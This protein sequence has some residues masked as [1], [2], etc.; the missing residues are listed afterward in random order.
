MQKILS[1]IIILVLALWLIGYG[2]NPL[3]VQAATPIIFI[4]PTG[5]IPGTSVTVTGA[6]FNVSDT[7]IVVTYDTTVVASGIS[8]N[9]LGGWSFTFP[10]PTAS[11]AGQHMIGAYSPSTPLPIVSPVPFTVTPVIYINPTSGIP[12]SSVTVTGAG[13]TANETGVVVTYSGVQVASGISTNPQ[14]GWSATFTIPASSAG[15]HIIDAGGPLTLATNVPD[16]SFTITPIISINRASGAPGSSTA[17]TGSGFGAGETN[18][19]ITYDGT[20]VFSGIS[21]DSQGGWSATFTVPASTYGSHTIDASGTSTSSTNVPDITFAITPGISINPTS[22]LPGSLVTVTSSGFGAGETGISVIYDGTVVSSGISASTQGGWSITFTIPPSASGSHTI[23]ANG[24]ATLATNIPD[25][26]FTV[27]PGISIS[28]TSGVPG[29]SVV[30]TGFGFGAGETGISVT[31]DGTVVSS[32]AKA[33]P[34][35]SWSATF[36]VPTSASGSHRVGARGSV[37]QTTRVSEAD[38][39]IGPGISASP[40]FGNVGAKIEIIGS[41]FAAN[42]PLRFIYDDKDIPTEGTS[43]DASGSFSKSIVVP[44][45]KAGPHTIKVNDGQRNESKTTF[46]MESTPPPVPAPLSPED[47]ARL[48]LLGGITPTLKWTTVTDPSGV[49]FVLQ[50]DTNPDFTSVILEKTD[51]VG[52]RYTLTVTEALPKGEYYWRVRAIDGASNQ[53]AWSA[54]RT[55]KSGL[56][57]LSTLVILIVLAVVVIAGVVYL[58]VIRRPQRRPARFPVPGVEMPQVVPGQWR[59]LEPE[60]SAR[61]RALPRILALPQP[62]KRAKTLSTE[63]MGRVKVILDF[64]QSLPLV[65][66]GYTANWLVDLVETSMGIEMSTPIYERL[67]KGELQL[68]YEP[69]WM[70]HPSYQDL[71][72]LLQ[73]QPILQE[74]DT[75]VDAVNHCAS[76]ATLLLQ[77]IYRDAIAEIPSDFLAKGG[78]EFISAVYSDALSWFLGKSLREPL[79][80]DYVIKPR[81]DT[82]EETSA[83]YLWGVESTSF[84]GPLIEVPDEKEALQVRALHLRLRRAYRSTDR[85]RQLVGIMAQLGVHRGRLVNAFSQF[86]QITQ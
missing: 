72:T 15:S 26:S 61:G 5:G 19:V 59:F 70:R 23:D 65:E 13:F 35:G 32:D 42:T 66:P 55:L 20:V 37:T 81:G 79:E 51:I 58:L 18:I 52:S 39:N 45:S 12:K 9:S 31:Y 53:S 74:L 57:A 1:R 28:R 77:D 27:I 41:G 68:R 36:V 8:A 76:E 29:N 38:F 84:A 60:E 21:A 2:A 78:W 7:G 82:G 63:D 30:V 67:L 49:T 62:T 71:T 46:T 64:A 48:G 17:V 80:R 73:G 14:G 86:G 11:F 16:I 4:S 75:F 24:S 83:L 44:K 69:A 43:T 22:G 40:D 56:M 33:N 3:P 50:V 6:S 25:I 54:T 85:A 34:L 47:G 10:V